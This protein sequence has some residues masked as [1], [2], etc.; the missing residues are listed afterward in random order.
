MA[1]K[2]RKKQTSQK[3]SAHTILNCLESIGVIPEST[4]GHIRISLFITE[5]PD[6]DNDSP[7]RAC[8]MREDINQWPDSLL[9]GC[10]V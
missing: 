9:L 5:L 4:R 7:S 10:C 6:F 1:V 2:V 3:R 8:V